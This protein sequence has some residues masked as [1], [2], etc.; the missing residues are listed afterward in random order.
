MKQRLQAR[1]QPLSFC[2]ADSTRRAADD[3]ARD[4]PQASEAAHTLDWANRGR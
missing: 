3:L 1:L 4:P 2:R